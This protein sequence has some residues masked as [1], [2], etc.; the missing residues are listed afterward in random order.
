MPNMSLI[1]VTVR[2]EHKLLQ[3]CRSGTAAGQGVFGIDNPTRSTTEVGYE[4][5]YTS[6]PPSVPSWH[7]TFM[8]QC[9]VI[10]SYKH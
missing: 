10:N 6:T 9:I 7:L 4:Y 5:I 1:Y 2:T 8:W 3:V